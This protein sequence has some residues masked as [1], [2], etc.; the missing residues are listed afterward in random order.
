MS[1]PWTTKQHLW[2]K[3][4]YNNGRTVTEFWEE[5]EPLFGVKRTK[6]AFY[7]YMKKIAKDEGALIT[8]HRKEWTEEEIKRLVKLHGVMTVPD[9]GRALGRTAGSV[10]GQIAK[11]RKEGTLGRKKRVRVC[12]LSE[13]E[14]AMER[15]WGL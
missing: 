3:E 12:W 5:F 8:H 10:Y 11:M 7:Q 15:E 6:C 2:V 14:Q 13:R 9:I 4:Q 1:E